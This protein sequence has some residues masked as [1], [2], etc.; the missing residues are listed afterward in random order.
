MQAGVDDEAHG[1]QHFHVEMAEHL[2]RVGEHAEF[3]AERFGVK[4]PTLGVGRGLPVPEQR[5]QVGI[6]DRERQLEMMAR[7][8][9]VQRQRLERRDR[10]CVQHR[11]VEKEDARRHAVGRSGAVI[12]GAA[13]IAERGQRADFEGRFG[14]IMEQSGNRRPDL[15]LDRLE[16]REQFGGGFVIISGVGADMLE[17]GLEVAREAHFGTDLFH[18]AADPRDFGQ[19]EHVD[20]VGRAPRRR[21]PREI[22]VVERGAVLHRP[23]TGRVGRVC[24]IG[25]AQIGRP[26]AVGGIDLVVDRGSER[27]GYPGAFGGG[28]RVRHPVDARPEGA[29]F[30]RQ[31]EHRVDLCEDIGDDGLRLQITFGPAFLQSGDG[32]V[33]IVHETVDAR[34][35]VVIVADGREGG[36]SA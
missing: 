25:S 4:A 5:W 3:G 16:P 20:V 11:H 33:H 36:G 8:P 12:S 10:S 34:E 14:A 1:A 29:F 30:D 21:V 9:L 31:R 2:H 35:G 27:V 13:L 28:E 15:R 19:A 18:L 32:A 24:Q 22:P 7:N 23:Q 17:K 6:F 26:G